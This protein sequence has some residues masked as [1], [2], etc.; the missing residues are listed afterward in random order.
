M[1]K[2]DDVKNYKTIEE[3]Q[4]ACLIEFKKCKKEPIYF[5]EN[6]VRV[7]T[8]GGEGT[9]LLKLR[10]FQKDYINIVN[11]KH[12]I[13]TL[14]SRQ[15]GIST[16][17]QAYIVW[18]LTFYN[19]VVV[20]VVSRDK[21]EASRF[22][23]VIKDMIEELPIWV[24]PQ[25]GRTNN[26]QSFDLKNG[27]Q[28]SAQCVNDT[29]PAN[30]FRGQPITIAVLDEAAFIS[31]INIAFGGFMMTT[32]KSQLSAKMA[33]A[34]YGTLVISTPQGTVGQGKWYYDMWQNS[35]AGIN[36]YAPFKVHWSQVPEYDDEWYRRQ[37][38]LLNW[39]KVLIA[40]EL[41]MAF[42]ASGNTFLD[43]DDI[44]RLKK[45]AV[46][47]IKTFNLPGGTLKLWDMPN[48]NSHYLIGVDTAQESG[49]DNSAMVIMDWEKWEQV[50]EYV[51]KLRVD[52][53]CKVVEKVHK[54]F[55][56]QLLI[57]ENNSYG[58][59][60]K[61]Y[62]TQNVDFSNK[63][64][65]KQK[66]VSQNAKPGINESYKWGL[67][68]NQ[69]TRPLIMDEIYANVRDCDHLIK[70]EFL[71]NELAA[72][73]RHGANMKIEAGTGSHDDACMSFGFCAYVR[74]YD[75]PTWF[76]SQK[77]S[78]QIKTI[79]NDL[80]DSIMNELTGFLDGP[81]DSEYNPSAI[82]VDV[83]EFYK[84]YNRLQK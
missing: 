38:Q 23:K 47:P 21:S 77:Q 57:V 69:R 33:G 19:G 16:I 9:Q 34:P 26:V 35:Q 41:E 2:D 24:R 59:Q 30:L 82:N 53:Y 10:D 25:Y 1:I 70:Q 52:E 8:P 68:T 4:L 7:S 64:I 36:E 46:P 6:Y 5:I 80:A 28:V 3:F 67:Q 84:Q 17:S 51:G 12:A 37:C 40:Q 18:A 55:P 65:Y 42:V 73:E 60:V 29:K 81:S 20:G 83:T 45:E 31:K 50:G 13:I 71:A 49:S 48:K 63:Y 39:D 54:L 32:A 75:P 66:V 62:I 44:K 22:C 14:K 72:L 27:G 61:D 56:E 76:P 74:K 79:Q 58:N 15:T 11:D 43:V 78:E